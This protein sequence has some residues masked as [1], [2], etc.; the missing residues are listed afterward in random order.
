MVRS[1]I[2]EKYN[3]K[4]YSDLRTC[5]NELTFGAEYD[6]FERETDM[7]HYVRH[8]DSNLAKLWIWIL[9]LN[10]RHKQNKMMPWLFSQQM[11]SLQNLML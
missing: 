9:V 10:T 2:A 8:M 11:V 5:A 6:F 7:M 3:L 1:E 4:T